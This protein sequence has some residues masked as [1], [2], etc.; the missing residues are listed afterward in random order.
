M[1]ENEFTIIDAWECLEA[2]CNH[3]GTPLMFAYQ[4]RASDIV[5]NVALKELQEE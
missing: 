3:L 2:L 5:E 1:D 4:E